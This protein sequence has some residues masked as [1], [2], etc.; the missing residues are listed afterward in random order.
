MNILAKHDT[1]KNRL[2]CFYRF[3]QER[4]RIRC[5][6]E[7]GEPRP[8]TDDKILDTYHFCNVRRADDRVTEWIGEWVK[9]NFMGTGNAWFAFAVARWFNEPE[10]LENMPVGLVEGGWQP[11]LVK[12]YLKKRVENGAPC[13]RGSYIITGAFSNKGQPKYESVVDKVLTPLWKDPPVISPTSIADSWNNLREYTGMGSFMAGQ[14][15]ADWQTFGVI[16]GRDVNTWAP[17]GPGS[18]RGLFW[19][20]QNHNKLGQ[21]Q[22]VR[23]MQECRQ[24]LIRRDAT[25]GLTLSL[26]DVQNCLCEF[27]K[28]TRG[29]AKTKYQPYQERL[30]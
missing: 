2:D 19:V 9:S 29:Y 26:H 6:K 3:V 5:A 28:Y 12:K 20:F 17:L 25:L 1:F 22:A 14:V 21:E 27:S 7:A 4:E 30:L 8:W 11:S 18:A 15:V 16:H 23:M 24:H 10:V 13:F